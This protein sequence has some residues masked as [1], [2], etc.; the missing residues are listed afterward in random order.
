MTHCCV[1][2]TRL[3]RAWASTSKVKTV[4]TC[5]EHSVQKQFHGVHERHSSY[6]QP[7]ELAFC[8]FLHKQRK[9]WLSL[10]LKPLHH[11]FHFFN[12]RWWDDEIQ[13]TVIK[14]MKH[15][16]VGGRS[17]HKINRKQTNC[18]LCRDLIL[19]NISAHTINLNLQFLWC[20]PH[21]C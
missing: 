1:S 13:H 12:I 9:D 18:R 3:W 17:V 14:R 20:V 15:H 16:Q 6:V 21:V 19:R 7:C 2:F 5:S 11:C 4:R 8:T 10:E